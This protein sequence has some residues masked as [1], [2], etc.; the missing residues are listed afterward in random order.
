MFSTHR[1]IPLF[2]ALN[3]LTVKRSFS[4]TINIPAQEDKF[5]N[6]YSKL[7][8]VVGLGEDSIS[9]Y[10]EKFGKE[11]SIGIETGKRK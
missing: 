10:A 2:F 6:L 4:Q 8:S 1:L 3:I 7:S 11:F 5:I 9:L